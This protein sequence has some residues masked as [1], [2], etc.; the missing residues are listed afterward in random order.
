MSTHE[1]KSESIQGMALPL[2]V[3]FRGTKYEY[4]CIPG[5]SVRDAKHRLVE[6]LPHEAVADELA[7]SD[8]KLVRANC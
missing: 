6:C 2:L 4:A 1:R 5:M 7:P 3:T 8:V